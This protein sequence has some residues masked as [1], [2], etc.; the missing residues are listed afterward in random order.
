[1]W[2]TWLVIILVL[3][4]VHGNR[5]PEIEFTFFEID[6][7]V[8]FII[9]F[10]LAILMCFAFYSSKNEPFSKRIVIIVAT[11]ILLGYFIEVIQGN[12]IKNRFFDVF[13]ILANSSGTILGSLLFKRI[14][15]IKLKFW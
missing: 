9:Y 4:F 10:I 6:K 15:K 12:F 13:D 1:M 3:S 8:H 2:I 7:L 11:G 5:I 14:M